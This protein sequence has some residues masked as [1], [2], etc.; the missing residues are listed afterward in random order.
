MAELHSRFGKFILVITK[1]LWSDRSGLKRQLGKHLV[2]ND[3]N[4]SVLYTT[5][6]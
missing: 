1:Q 6:R 5:S 3:R 2:T 4:R